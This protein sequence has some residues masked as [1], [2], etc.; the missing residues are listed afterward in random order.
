M[1][2]LK[3]KDENNHFIPV[4][5]DVKVNSTSVFDGK[6]A[7]VQLKTINYQSIV[8][9]GNIEVA[10]GGEYVEYS[11]NQGLNATEKANARANIDAENVGN[12]V[13]SISSSS[14]NAQYPTAKC[15]YD[16]I[17]DIEQ[18]LSEV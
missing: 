4:V 9:T 10:S 15:M 6:D 2:K 12:K 16:L 18:A 5:Q 13:T 17:G 1:A 11:P 14:T 3:F 8:G 7:N